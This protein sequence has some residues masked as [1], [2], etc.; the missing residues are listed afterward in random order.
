MHLDSP[1]SG[2]EA[3]AGERLRAE[4]RSL[5]GEIMAFA[6]DYDAVL[7]A[8]DL[9]DCGYVSPDTVGA[10]RDALEAYGRPVVIAPGNHDP[11]V[12]G[13]V[14]TLGKWSDNV[15][16]FS[17]PELSRFDI[18][19]GGGPVTVWGWAFTSDRMDSCPLNRGLSP[20]AGRLNLIC[21]H[22]DMSSP[23]SRYCPVTETALSLSGCDYA[24]LGHIH[25]APPF[26]VYGRTL[27]SYCGFPEGRSWDEPGNGTVV[28]V[29]FEEGNP[30][31]IEKIVTGHHR[32]E[33]MTADITGEDSDSGTAARLAAMA[34]GL[35]NTSVMFRLEGAVPPDYRPD[36]E[37]IAAAVAEAARRGDVSVTVRDNTLPV[38]GAEYLG[39]D[40]TVRGE[41]YRSLLPGLSSADA[42][43]RRLASEALRIG[44]LALENRPF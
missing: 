43:E 32:Y 18:E 9:F 14:W 23:I 42:D 39:S 16:I 28:S 31:T 17:S 36:T 3:S 22:G 30:P 4:L 35:A 25:K 1:F 8:G 29:T 6:A 5:F 15:F 7:I 24:A 41:F 38:L 12:Q 40:M 26:A 20:A 19:T 27:A 44:L 2:V 33:I 21:A 10:V 37:R 11:Y 13:S 34:A